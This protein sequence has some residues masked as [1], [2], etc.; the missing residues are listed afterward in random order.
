M[1]NNVIQG[2]LLI[3]LG[4]GLLSIMGAIIKYLSNDMPTE[5][6]VFYRNLFG[7][8][9]LVPIILHSGVS[10]LKTKVMHLHLVRAGVG[11]TAMYGFFYVIANMPLAEAFLVKLTSPFFMPIV[12]AIWLAETIKPKTGWAIAIGFIGVMFILR[13][14]TEEFTPIALIGLLSAALASTA[15]VSIRRMSMTESSVRIV[16]YFGVIST[17]LSAIPLIWSPYLPS[18]ELLPWIVLMGLVATCGQLALT[19]AYRIAN[20]GQIG[21]YVYSSVIY[22]AVLGWVFWGETLVLT[23]IIGSALIVTAGI[24][25]ASGKKQTN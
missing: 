8:I 5:H 12:A 23:T 18:L 16:F 15:K 19:R 11:L 9:M 25:N 6:I 22:G 20:P 14:G 1:P 10:Q 2:A 4:E 21:P 24:W 7:L 17:V 3:L 13:P